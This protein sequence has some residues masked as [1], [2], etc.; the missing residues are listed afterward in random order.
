MKK[1]IDFI[2]I[3]FLYFIT[4]SVYVLLF[5][6]GET[7]IEKWLHNSWISQLYMYIGKLFLV[8]S[9]YFLPNKIGI[10][11]RFFY[12]FLIYILVMV[13]VFVLLDILGLLSE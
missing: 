5:I 7:Y 6:E 9:I 8:I 10:Q 4:L 11:I 13:P 2:K 3:F 1:I 12:K